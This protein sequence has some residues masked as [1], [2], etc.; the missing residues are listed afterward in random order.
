MGK[1]LSLRGK[2]EE[3]YWGKENVIPSEGFM[4]FQKIKTES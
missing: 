2:T 3:K 4:L 1:I